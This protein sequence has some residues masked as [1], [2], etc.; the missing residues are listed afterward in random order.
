M[1]VGALVF[2]G[3]AVRVRVGVAVAG[4][5]VLVRVA[6]AVGVGVRV[7]VGVGVGG[8]TPDTESDSVPLAASPWKLPWA[9]R[10]V[11]PSPCTMPIEPLAPQVKFNATSLPV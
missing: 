7:R 2:V 9:V 10:P 6:V 8:Q 3:V 5:G 4:P 11:L 1:L